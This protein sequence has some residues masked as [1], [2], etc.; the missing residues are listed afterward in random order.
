MEKETVEIP[1]GK[2]FHT[3][4]GPKT[5]E[6]SLRADSYFSLVRSQ[7]SEYKVERRISMEIVDKG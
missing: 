7:E 4:G 6:S 3:K 1:G 5:S 2:S